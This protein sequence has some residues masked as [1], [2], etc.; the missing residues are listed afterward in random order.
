M[1]LEDVYLEGPAGEKIVKKHGV[2]REEI[3]TVLLADEPK[4]FKTK[5]GRYLAIDVTERY[6]T[7][8]YE[9]RKG[10]AVIVT[11]Y[12]SSQWQ[13]KLYKRK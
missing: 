1:H 12:P 3:E 4:H 2:S 11:A 6:L 10:I 8:V 13:V 5:A 9:N 7:I